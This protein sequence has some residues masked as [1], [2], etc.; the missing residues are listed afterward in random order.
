MFILGLLNSFNKSI[1]DKKEERKKEE[2][3]NDWFL[4]AREEQEK[5]DITD[6]LE[7]LDK[8]NKG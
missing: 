2:E 8:K 5:R 7:K 3:K 6:K 1:K 4:T